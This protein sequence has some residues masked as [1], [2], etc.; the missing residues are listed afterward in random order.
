MPNTIYRYTFAC[1]DYL[2]QRVCCG[3]INWKLFTD[4]RVMRLHELSIEATKSIK[5]SALCRFVTGALN[6]F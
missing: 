5:L 6:K 3:L 4:T 1:W 2:E